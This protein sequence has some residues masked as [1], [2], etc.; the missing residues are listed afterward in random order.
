MSIPI[1]LKDFLEMHNVQYEHD[2]HPEVYTTQELAAV[3]HEPGM[4]VVKVVVVK[5]DDRFVL[6]ALPAPYSI[7]F[8]KMKRILNAKE[9]RLATEEEFKDLFP[10]CDVGAMPPFGELYHMEMWVDEHMRDN[11]RILFNAGTHRD[12]IKM[13]YGDFERIFHP[14]SGDFSKLIS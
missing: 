10:E 7:D 9:A 3:E 1:A 8:G 5:A 2:T 6:A 13:W 14:K 4:H 11:D 12:A